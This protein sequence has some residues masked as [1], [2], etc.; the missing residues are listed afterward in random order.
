MFEPAGTVSVNGNILTSDQPVISVSDQGLM[1]GWG[2]FET[3]RVYRGRPW[4]LEKHL[5]RMLGSAADIEI[6]TNVPAEEIVKWVRSFLASAG[7]DEG[8]LRITLT[9]A[10]GYI[11]NIILTYRPLIYTSEQYQAGFKAM[12]SPIRR[13]AHS[14]MVGIKSLNYMDNMLAKRQAARLGFDEAVMLNGS[15]ILCECTMSN[16]FFVKSG[17]LYTP[18]LKCGVLA[19]ITRGVV[20]GS[21]A[22]LIDI[23]VREG[24]YVLE[25]LAQAEEAFITNSVM[26]TTPLVSLDGIRIGDGRPGK[27]TQTI[28]IK[29]DELVQKHI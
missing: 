9:R 16:I 11:S 10:Q 17:C 29:H 26:Q 4:L 1:Y 25:H 28:M 15:G 24:E 2:V 7:I 20:I 12:T 8:V 13:N 14:P 3:I 22:P 21:I 23:T 27:L 5:D 6:E 19:G 18:A